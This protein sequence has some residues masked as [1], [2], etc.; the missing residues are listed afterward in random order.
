MQNIGPMHLSEALREHRC[1][2][3][4]KSTELKK[5]IFEK[6]CIQVPTTDKLEW[7]EKYFFWKSTFERFS[8]ESEHI[9]IEKLP[10]KAICNDLARTA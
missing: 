5:T 9:Y 1:L 7:T 3:K 8:F 10:L 6:W 4:V 2:Y